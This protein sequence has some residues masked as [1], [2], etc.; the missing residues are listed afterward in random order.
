MGAYPIDR[1]EA[2]SCNGGQALKIDA[3]IA[4]E[5]NSID[6]G[7]VVSRCRFEYI[8]DCNEADVKALLGLLKLTFYRFLTRQG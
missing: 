5:L 1:V 4:S 3:L 6:D 8:R 2:Y 7:I